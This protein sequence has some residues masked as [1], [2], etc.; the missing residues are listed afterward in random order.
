MPQPSV[1]WKP[2]WQWNNFLGKW[3]IDW[4]TTTRRSSR[5]VTLRRTKSLKRSQVGVASGSLFINTDSLI[6]V[7]LAHMCRP[8]EKSNHWQQ[9][10]Q[11]LSEGSDFPRHSGA[12]F[13]SAGTQHGKGNLSSERYGRSLEWCLGHTL[14]AFWN[15]RS[16]NDCLSQFSADNESR[17]RWE[18]DVFHILWVGCC[19]YA[20][21][22]GDGTSPRW[23]PFWR[24]CT[25]SQE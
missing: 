22:Q 16:P 25:V 9:G 13:A 18:C 5:S 12:L 19:L 2:T 17:D 11:V 3:K 20:V 15:V 10:R 23:G 6:T 4:C 14:Y 21:G 8:L 1:N 24:N 7:L